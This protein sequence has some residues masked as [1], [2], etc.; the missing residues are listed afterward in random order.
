MT[1]LEKL[2]HLDSK[3]RLVASAT[4]PLRTRLHLSPALRDSTARWRVHASRLAHV[5][6]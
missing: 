5:R 2:L 3:L 6:M 1:L 4:R